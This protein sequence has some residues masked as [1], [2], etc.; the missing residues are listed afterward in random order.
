M[1]EIEQ[2]LINQRDQILSTARKHGA[3]DIR[4]FGSVAR[5][6]ADEDS[7]VDFLVKL[8]TG[9]SLMDLA[10][11]LLELQSLLGLKVDVM[12]ENGLRKRIRSQVLK[13]ARYF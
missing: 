7:D 3:Y 4:I 12:T 9:R 8:D 11:L 13:E 5:G 6:D 1:M 2:I 10:R